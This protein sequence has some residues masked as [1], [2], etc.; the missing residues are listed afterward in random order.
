MIMIIFDNHKIER[1]FADLR[2]DRQSLRERCTHNK[3][4]LDNIAELYSIWKSSGS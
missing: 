2:D 1:K 3:M 4:S